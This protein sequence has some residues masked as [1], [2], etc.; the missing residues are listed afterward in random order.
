MRSRND[1]LALREAVK[2]GLIDCIASHHMPQEWDSKTCEFEYA[3]NGMIGLQ[4]SFASVKTAIPGLTSKQIEDLFSLN[5]RKIFGLPVS[6]IDEGANADIT[7]FSEQ[8]NTLFTKANNKSKS[9]NSP[10]IDVALNGKVIGV[11]N[12]GNLFIND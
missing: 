2:N 4:T 10:F 8:E 7:L 9:I 5:A 1:M 6:T 12:K 3:K 11:Y